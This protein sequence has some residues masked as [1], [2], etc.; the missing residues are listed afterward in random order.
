MFVN[1][2]RDEGPSCRTASRSQ[3]S[4]GRDLPLRFSV[5]V[6]SARCDQGTAGHE[7]SSVGVCVSRFW[8]W[9]LSPGQRGR[10]SPSRPPPMTP[11]GLPS[12]RVGELSGICSCEDTNPVRLGVLPLVTSVNLYFLDASSP[13]M[14]VCWGSG[15]QPVGPRGHRHSPHVSVL[16]RFH[17]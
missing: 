5:S 10:G 1:I 3:F 14:A 7:A 8:G 9:A 12:V 2:H 16:S 6:S 15:H 17:A 4:A 11:V 13:D